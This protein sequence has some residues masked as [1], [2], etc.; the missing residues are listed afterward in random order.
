MNSTLKTFLA[1]TLIA[2][3]ALGCS[4]A[5]DDDNTVETTSELRGERGDDAERQETR[6]P[7]RDLERDLRDAQIDR[8]PTRDDGV[9]RRAALHRLKLQC[10][11]DCTERARGFYNKCVD[12]AGERFCV[13]L[14]H[15]NARECVA[16]FCSR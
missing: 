3:P 8:V 7:V 10:Q 6:E 13:G 1:V 5:I 11:S 16:D 14:A 4:D 15:E 12:R 9:N 2:L